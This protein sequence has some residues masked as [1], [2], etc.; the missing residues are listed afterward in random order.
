MTT[1]KRKASR[2]PRDENLLMREAQSSAPMAQTLKIR[3]R[4]ENDQCVELLRSFNDGISIPVVIDGKSATYR[5]TQ[6]SISE[7]VANFELVDVPVRESR[8]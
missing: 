1:K 4:L 8:A 2:I 7:N 3:A 6:F 5:V